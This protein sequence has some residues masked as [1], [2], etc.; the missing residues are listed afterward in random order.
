VYFSSQSNLEKFFDDDYL[1]D[2][3][4]AEKKLNAKHQFNTRFI[5]D[6]INGQYE[7]LFLKYI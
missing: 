3:L 2:Q 6:D 4:V 1:D 7:A 5:W